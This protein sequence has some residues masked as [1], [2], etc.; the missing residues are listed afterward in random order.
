[1]AFRRMAFHHPPPTSPSFGEVST[2]ST[3][4]FGEESA[5]G[6]VSTTPALGE[7]S[8]TPRPGLKYGYIR[9]EGRRVSGIG[10]VVVKSDVDN[11][12]MAIPDF[13]TMR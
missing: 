11:W 6:E 1:M 2:V 8:T 10:C 3:P 7:A 5:F 12:P 13:I 9:I 4:A